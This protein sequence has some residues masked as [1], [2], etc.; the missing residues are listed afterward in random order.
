VTLESLRAPPAVSPAAVFAYQH[1]WNRSR[2]SW[3]YEALASRDD[4]DAPE[5]SEWGAAFPGCNGRAQ[6]PVDIVTRDVRAAAGAEPLRLTLTTVKAGKLVIS[7]NGRAV[8][9]DGLALQQA[10]T[11]EVGS[12]VYS[13]QELVLHAGSE[14]LVDGKRAALELHFVLRAPTGRVAVLAV[15][16][17]VGSPG[18][19]VSVL[20][21][22]RLG[23]GQARATSRALELAALLPAGREYFAYNGSLST[24]PCTEGVQWFVLLERG[25]VAQEQLDLFPLWRNHRPAQPL[26]GRIVQ[27]SAP[28][29]A[30][31]LPSTLPP[32][33][34]VGLPSDGPPGSF[35]SRAEAEAA[36]E[37]L[38]CSGV[39]L[40]S[41]GRML[42]RAR[43]V[44][45]K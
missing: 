17:D 34:T 3:R 1:V 8:V 43:V 11:L 40:T 36:S 20:D 15:L 14:T 22:N 37:A 27:R 2:Y 42:A 23:E 33:G 19:A 31:L 45:V 24:P 44:G 25:S 30:P 18:S 29:L 26:N 7:N 39:P 12:V 21:W 9:V 5:P 38:G 10:A 35:G 13:L 32:I 4:R 28:I 6:S 41:R 16:C